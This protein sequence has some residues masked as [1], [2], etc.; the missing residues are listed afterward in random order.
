[1]WPVKKS[2]LARSTSI[3][4]MNCVAFITDSEFAQRGLRK[5]KEK[6]YCNF[7]FLS[8]KEMKSSNFNEDQ[9]GKLCSVSLHLLA[10]HTFWLFS[11]WWR[12]FIFFFS[13]HANS[14]ISFPQFSVFLLD[15]F[16]WFCS[17]S[18][19]FVGCAERRN[20]QAVMKR[21]IKVR[22]PYKQQS[23]VMRK[24]REKES[25]LWGLAPGNSCMWELTET[26]YENFTVKL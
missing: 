20:N 9:F 7:N 3:A 12:F 5:G 1:M 16:P 21:T 8:G 19:E 11:F 17:I 10:S 22:W 6:K 2:Q 25:V 23:G 18:E 15:Y 14:F 24:K 4:Q 26:K 13:I